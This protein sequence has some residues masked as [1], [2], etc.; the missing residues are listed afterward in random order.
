MH[1]EVERCLYFRFAFAADFKL[2]VD[3]NFHDIRGTII[4]L[5]FNCG[6]DYHLPQCGTVKNH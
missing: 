3:R 4:P 2:D 1:A 5:T 6:I